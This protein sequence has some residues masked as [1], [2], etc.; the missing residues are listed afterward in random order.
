MQTGEP[1][2]LSGKLGTATVYL[3]DPDGNGRGPI[4]LIELAGT[5][6]AKSTLT[7]TTKKPPNGT[8][9]RAESAQ[10]QP[11][12]P[13]LSGSDRAAQVKGGGRCELRILYGT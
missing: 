3:T 11:G 2:A 8:G 10:E 7:I 9:D 13:V 5:D 6:P 1:I 4:E 12:R